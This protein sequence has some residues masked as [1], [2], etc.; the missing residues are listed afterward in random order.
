MLNLRP[1]LALVFCAVALHAQAPT[2]LDEALNKVAK[3]QGRWAYTETDLLRNGRDKVIVS[4]EVRF[5]PS[6]PYPDQY[7]PIKINGQAPTPSDLRRYRAKGEKR[8]RDLEKPKNAGRAD[9]Q[10]TLGELVAIDRAVIASEDADAVTYDVPLKVNQRFPPDKFQVLIRVSKAKRALEHV[11]VRL[12]APVRMAMV[13]DVKS[14]ELEADF[15]Q[16]DQKHSPAM[17][18]L[19]G[20]GRMSVF[21]LPI[22]RSGEMTRT[23]FKHVR[24]FDERFGVEIGPVKALDF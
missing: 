23:D 10:P 16:V 18:S 17:T 24:P 13:L 4:T 15:S 8:G 20:D 12:R 22:V 21:F 2:L 7:E 6:K 3:D 11:A 5:D 19:R 9:P 14:G 1:A